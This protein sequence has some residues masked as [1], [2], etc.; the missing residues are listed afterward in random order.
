VGE[1]CLWLLIIA[2]ALALLAYVAGYLR[3]VVLPVGIALVL[4]TF[5]SPLAGFL[6]RR[7]W[8][9]AA[10]ALASVLAFLATLVALVSAV[11][12]RT[13]DQFRDLDVSLT[14]GIDEVRG[15]LSDGPLGLSENQLDDL[16][17][18]GRSQLEEQQDTL[19]SG[20]LTGAVLAVEL[21]AGLVLAIVL[22]F[23]FLKDGPKLW[24]WVVS[25]APPRSQRQV[26]ELGNRSWTALAGFLRGQTIVAAFDAF[27]IG[28]GL[29]ILGVPLVLPLVV[30]TFFAAYIPILGAFAAGFAA[31]MVALVAEGFVTALIVLGVIVAVQQIESNVLEP[32]VVGR[33]VKVH[34]I[35]ILL[36]V[37]AGLVTAGIIGALVATP[38]IAVAG[39][40]LAYV[41]SDEWENPPRVDANASGDD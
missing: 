4:A 34:P 19:I 20:A 17:D 22:L 21:V 37:S 10:A 24:G 9:N 25:L 8:P 31:V 2:A 13:V 40:M 5:L 18:Q 6:R 32:V 33:T 28:L 41:R 39:A 29:L 36:G 26:D 15:W 14:E 27:F 30:L 16:I 23:F 11:G 1:A 35:A 12:P 3:I 7:S 38:I